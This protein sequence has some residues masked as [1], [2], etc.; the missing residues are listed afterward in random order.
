MN[1]LTQFKKNSKSTLLY[2]VHAGV[3]DLLWRT[4]LYRELKR[5]NPVM[6]LIISGIDRNSDSIW[7]SIYKN[8]PDIDELRTELED[9]QNW[10]ND[11]DE[12]ISDALC[13]HVISDYSKEMHAIDALGK[14]A[15]LTIYDKSYWYE[16]TEEEKKW[17]DSFLKN[18][19]ASKIVGVGIRASTWVRTWSF[20]KTKK[21]VKLLIQNGYKVVM[22]NSTEID[23][24]DIDLI[25]MCGGYTIREVAAVI[26][27][28]DMLITPD[29]GYLHLAGHFKIPTLALFGCTDP[30]HRIKYYPTVSAILGKPQLNCWPCFIH[31]SQCNYGIPSPCMDNI[32]VEDVLEQINKMGVL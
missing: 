12:F 19:E 3:G 8:N 16:S 25:N 13:P 9:D 20:I 11:V 1:L 29:T 27:K 23:L 4:A 26:E 6:K 24:K 7:R 21:I 18:H 15:G 31:A 14:W 28:L 5:R 22:F 17:A 30:E 2:K 10:L 32:Q